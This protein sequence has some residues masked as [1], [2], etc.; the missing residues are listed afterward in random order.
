M[1][2]SNK[3]PAKQV[4]RAAPLRLDCQ[5]C[6]NTTDHALWWIVPGKNLRYMGMV[7][8]GTKRYVYV[9]PICKNIAQEV[10]KEQVAA[11]KV[12]A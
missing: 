10:T 2:F 9:C 11:L 4:R 6:K 7:V 5:N 12:G 8:A 3:M 1:L